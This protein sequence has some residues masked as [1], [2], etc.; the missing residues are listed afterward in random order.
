MLLSDNKATNCSMYIF[1]ADM[2]G[3]LNYFSANSQKYFYCCTM[4]VVTIISLIPTHAHP[5]YTLKTLIHINT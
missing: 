2:F 3:I 5:L 4:H 1:L